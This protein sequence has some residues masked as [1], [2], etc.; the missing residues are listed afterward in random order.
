M[1]PEDLAKALGAQRTGAAWMARCPAHDDQTPSLSIGVGRAGTIL[2]RCH[3]GCSQREVIAAL[4]ERRLW[5]EGS[6]PLDHH[7][8]NRSYIISKPV[9]AADTALRGVAMTIWK[10]SGSANGSAA[11]TYLRARG[12]RLAVPDSLRFHRSL[13]HPEGAKWPA[14]VALVADGATGAPV[15]IHRTYLSAD[16][17]RK[18]P[19]TPPK[20]ML[21]S[22]RGGVVRL[23]EPDDVL[24][25][26]EGIETCLAAMQASGLSAWAALSTSG[27]RSLDLPA[28]VR[29]IVVLA[30]GD[31]P[32]EA[33]AQDCAL[34]WRGEG[35]EVR[36]ARPPR[37]MDFC[38]LLKTDPGETVESVL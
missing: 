28:N 27:L 15:A 30:D 17:S 21:G 10:A 37:G 36:I 5:K 6:I 24:L 32:G 8:R 22:C 26:G 12:I 3:A 1:T 33:A 11:E 16:G 13:K 14:M 4:S 29:N 19:V 34:R 18:A 7:A 25:V 23:G 2:V 38:D 20:M 9:E 31:D 35:R